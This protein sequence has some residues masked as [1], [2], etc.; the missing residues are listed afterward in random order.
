MA[1]FHL[2]LASMEDTMFRVTSMYL[3]A[4]YFRHKEGRKSDFEFSGLKN[5]FANM[6]LLNI[7]IA[8]RIKNATQTDSSLNAV[9]QAGYILRNDAIYS[10]HICGNGARFIFCQRL[11]VIVTCHKTKHSLSF[12]NHRQ[13]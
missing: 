10:L 2:P 6:H 12:D 1:R 7:M 8:E 9:I 5:I 11:F 4:Q 13:S 3:M